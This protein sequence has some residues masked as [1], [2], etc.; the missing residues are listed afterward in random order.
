MNRWMNELLYPPGFTLI[1]DN[2][3][4]AFPVHVHDLTPSMTAELVDANMAKVIRWLKLVGPAQRRELHCG[5]PR[6]LQWKFCT[7]RF[8][9]TIHL[10]IEP[11]SIYPKHIGWLFVLL[12]FT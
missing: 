6:Q 11:C 1:A 5:P 10:V 9:A 3:H 12:V 2:L 8:S 7:E 4:E